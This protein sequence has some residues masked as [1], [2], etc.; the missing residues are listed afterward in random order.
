MAGEFDGIAD[1]WL[2][3]LLQSFGGED[4]QAPEQTDV[5]ADIADERTRDALTDLAPAGLGK[6]PFDAQLESTS[7]FDLYI[8]KIS[9]QPYINEAIKLSQDPSRVHAAT[10]RRSARSQKQKRRLG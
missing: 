3:K 9:T 8:E 6:T 4:I 10:G 2:G 5:F 7:D 1:T